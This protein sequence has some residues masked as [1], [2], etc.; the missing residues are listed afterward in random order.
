MAWAKNGTPVTLGSASDNMDITDLTASKFHILLTHK[1]NAASDFGGAITFDDDSGSN[2]ADRRK[3]D[4][5]TEATDVNQTSTRSKTGWN[6]NDF[7]IHSICD[8][9]GEETLLISHGV[10]ERSAG[11]GTAPGRMELISKWTGTTQFTRM[12]MTKS[13]AAQFDTNSNV[14]MLGSEGVASLNVQDGAVYY[15]T[16]L[17]KSYVLY[18]NA[19]TEL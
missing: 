13:G 5:G 19:W 7:F 8:I 17:N 16:D 11:A 9:S 15:D 6:D 10:G 1:I 12:D 2:Y 14:S 3:N 4:G 18:N